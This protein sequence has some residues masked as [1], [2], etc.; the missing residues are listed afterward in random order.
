MDDTPLFPKC[1][2]T[3][4]QFVIDWA[5]YG[6][7]C[8]LSTGIFF[9]INTFYDWKDEGLYEKMWAIVVCIVVV[10]GI[11]IILP[12]FLILEVI[13]FLCF[14]LGMITYILTKKYYQSYPPPPQS[15]RSQNSSRLSASSG[16]N[17]T[18]P[19][20]ERGRFS[21]TISLNLSS[22]SNV[23]EHAV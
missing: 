17:L 18:K 19:A 4:K 1:V 14:P 20:L 8:L 23:E 2:E 22:I 9:V 21:S 7:L 12:L 6:P 15:L 3:E 16:Q 11:W 5:L 13:K 10:F